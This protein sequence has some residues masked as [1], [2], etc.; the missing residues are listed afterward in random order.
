MDADQL[1]T[2][3]AALA[4]QIER[5][6]RRL[7]TQQQQIK[8]TQETA[9]Q[10]HRVLVDIVDRVQ[11]LA[12]HTTHGRR[13]PGA[14]TA[15]APVSW[16]TINDP[17]TART[18][19][20]DLVDWL[21]RVYTHYPGAVDAL[22]E[23]WHHHPNAIEELLALRAAWH[24]AYTSPDAAPTRAIDW[25]DRHLPGVIHRLRATLGNCSLPAHQ[26]G[27]RANQPRPA[28]PATY[29]PDELVRLWATATR[30]S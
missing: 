22:G 6:Q 27:G 11:D 2:I 10:T 13:Q 12:N 30:P 24:A 18:L 16:L 7:D 1:N 9:E 28:I 23:C 4:A 21:N 3:L 29:D 14:S 25:H 19:L 20:A 17:A 15:G 5:L 26:P 8:Q